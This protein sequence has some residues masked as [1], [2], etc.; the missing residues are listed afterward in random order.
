MVEVVENKNRAGLGFQR[1]LSHVKAEDI[2]PSFRSGG[3]IHGNEQHSAAVIEGDE[4]EDYAN[5]V[6]HGKTCNN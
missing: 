1:G 6:T 2:Q 5:F 4:D 3:F